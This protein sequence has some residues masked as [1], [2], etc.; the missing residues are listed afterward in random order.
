[1]C[2]QFAKPNPERVSR[3]VERAILPPRCFYPLPTP[4]AGACSSTAGC[5]N[6][7]EARDR[8]R[9]RPVRGLR[10][11]LLGLEYRRS[12]I[13]FCRIFVFG[14]AR[15]RYATDHMFLR[16]NH[17]QVGTDAAA[18]V[19]NHSCV[20]G[21]SCL[22]HPFLGARLRSFAA[23]LTA[24]ALAVGIQTTCRGFAR[25]RGWRS[26]AAQFVRVFSGRLAGGGGAQR[27]SPC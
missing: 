17:Q 21:R 27:V 14:I 8:K 15:S 4:A 7:P 19:P 20:D 26:V 10:I 23:K 13:V 25:L 6:F 18:R 16:G 22:P 5:Q 24:N 2:F 3:L 1:M 9:N 11:A 12:T